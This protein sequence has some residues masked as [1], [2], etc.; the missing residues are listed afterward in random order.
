MTKPKFTLRLEEKHGIAVIF[1]PPKWIIEHTTVS[2]KGC[3]TA[4][5]F[6]D[7]GLTIVTKLNELPITSE[8]DYYHNLENIGSIISD[9]CQTW[10][11]TN[12]PEDQEKFKGVVMQED[13]L[14]EDI[15]GWMPK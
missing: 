7:L 4:V 8:I 9:C 14:K 3:V 2:M 15:A 12:N 13:T 10:N 5:P 1:D 6:E 11:I